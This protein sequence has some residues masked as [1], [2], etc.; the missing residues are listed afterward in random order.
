MS[1]LPTQ[2]SLA[3]YA[4]GSNDI[5]CV[6]RCQCCEVHCLDSTLARLNI[7]LRLPLQHYCKAN[8]IVKI[9]QTKYII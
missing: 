1:A 5:F 6:P 3:I 2:K 8:Q 7:L 9:E 4:G